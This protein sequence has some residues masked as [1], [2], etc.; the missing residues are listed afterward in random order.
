[1]LRKI[2]A[3]S[4]CVFLFSF[5]SNAQAPKYTPLPQD[6]PK[7]EAVDIGLAGGGKPDIVRFLNVRGISSPSISPDGSRVV[8]VTS[9]TGQSQLWV[10][11]A[12][13]DTPTQITFRPTSVNA[14]GWSPSGEWIAYSSTRPGS[15]RRGFYLVSPDGLQERELIAPDKAFMQWGGWSPDG[16]RIAF[17]S[18]ERNGKDY[19]IYLVDIAAEGSHSAPR[20]VYEGEGLLSVAA[21]RP[22]G[23]ALLLSQAR[24]TAENDLYL[25]DLSTGKSE[26]LFKTEEGAAYRSFDWTLDSKGFYMITNHERDL[27]GVAFYDAATRNLSWIETPAVE[28]DQVALSAD[29]KY[30]AWTYN[31]NGYSLLHLRETKS[32]RQITAQPALPP[33]VYSIQWAS[34]APTLAVR[35]AGPQLEGDLWTLNAQTGKTARMTRSATGGLDPSR[36]VMPEAVAFSS[37][38]SEKVYGLLYLPR[39]VP[40][41]TKPP[42]VIQVHGGGSLVQARPD[43]NPLVQYLVT[44]GIAVF[45]LNYRGSRGY[46]KRFT[47]IDNQRLRPNEVKDIAGA[48]DW[49]GK[50]GKIDASRAAVMGG[51]HGGYLTMAALTQFPDR[52]RAGVE[53]S[54]VSNWIAALE[55]ALPRQK[56][57]DRIEFGNID[58][59][60]DR[61]FLIELSPITHVKN[62]KTP[63]LAIHGTDDNAV[64]VSQTDDFVAAIRQLGGSIEYLRFPNEGHQFGQWRLSDRVIG[65][66]HIARFL[67]RTL[68]D[69]N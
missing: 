38:D 36:F 15:E 11:G 55:N 32:K 37:W 6:T 50:T 13:G 18:P 54:G 40:R 21:W 5:P 35:I 7:P 20:R 66:R 33:G 3:L 25:L 2:F 56:A 61:K 42:V 52:F 44:R 48:L 69:K 4:C 51:S 23:G 34:K 65:Y 9:T 62:I 39:D 1:M 46:G 68:G 22:D 47:R 28:V 53:W 43:Y 64:P 67:E 19:D 12:L 26:T 30:L 14:L 24:G 59:P 45:D 57:T 41:G 60:E 31:E 16:R 29:G 58:D 8:Y 49:I 17:A 63:L 27:T 10:A